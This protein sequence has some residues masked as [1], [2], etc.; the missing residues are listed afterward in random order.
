MRRTASAAQV[1]PAEKVALSDT[2]SGVPR[3]PRRRA[4]AAVVDNLHPELRA[5]RAGVLHEEAHLPE[6]RPMHIGGEV[7]LLPAGS[8]RE[9]LAGGADHERLV[10]GDDAARRP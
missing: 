8:D 3:P 9:W 6:S 4:D 10:A 5:G 2:P 1:F 7:A